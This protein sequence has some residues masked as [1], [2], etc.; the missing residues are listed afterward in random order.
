ML[1]ELFGRF[2]FAEFCYARQSLNKFNLTPAA[3]IL[4]CGLFNKQATRRIRAAAGE[5]VWF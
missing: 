4:S 1:A 2:S 3:R 5:M